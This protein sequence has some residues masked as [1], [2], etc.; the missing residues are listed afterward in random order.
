MAAVGAPVVFVCVLLVE[1]GGASR[2]GPTPDGSV[3]GSKTA[4][5]I[6]GQRLTVSG[7][8]G[9]ALKAT[10]RRGVGPPRWLEHFLAAPPTGPIGRLVG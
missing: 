10:R 2:W 9:R 4:Q 8:K 6:V 1:G 3:S 7:G 5:L